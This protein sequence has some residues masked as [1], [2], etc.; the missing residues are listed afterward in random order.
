MK[1]TQYGNILRVEPAGE[2]PLLLPS[3][4]HKQL[5]VID[6][7]YANANTPG[8]EFA[9]HFTEW[10]YNYHTDVPWKCNTDKY[11]RPEEQARFIKA[12]ILQHPKSHAPATTPG[13]EIPS[14][15]LA[16]FKLDARVPPNLSYAEEERRREESI[17]TQ[18]SQLMHEARLWRV[19]NSAQWVA[20]GIVQAKVPG[21]E[22]ALS[23]AHAI[24][25]NNNT[26]NPKATSS[27]PATTTTADTPSASP[28]T[29][30]NP[31]PPPPHPHPP[32]EHETDDNEQGFDYLAYAQDRALFFW[33]D[34]LELGLVAEEQLP[35][36]VCRRAKRLKY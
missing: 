4:E 2:S 34:L 20:W 6:F 22:E 13:S 35:D 14:K 23:Q 7:E 29:T 19:A 30:P 18:I 8:H 11:P 12:Y 15:A 32:H 3:N 26:N 31:A 25:H 24:T 17:K 16:T 36:E 1:Q 21:M 10:C 28:N 9:N 33:G 27:T 5:V